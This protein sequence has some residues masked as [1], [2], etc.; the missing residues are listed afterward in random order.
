MKKWALYL[1]FAFVSFNMNAQTVNSSCEAPDSIRALFLHDASFLALQKTQAIN[2]DP[3]IFPDQSIQ[4]TILSALLAVYNA[5]ELVSS[6]QVNHVYNIHAA[7]EKQ[8]REFAFTLDPGAINNLDEYLIDTIINQTGNASFDEA[9]DLYNLK[10]TYFNWNYDSTSLIAQVKPQQ[11]LAIEKVVEEI[12]SYN[13]VIDVATI[14]WEEQATRFIEYTAHSHFS[15]L[16]YIYRWGNCMNGC[17]FE[18]SWTFRVHPNCD[19]EFVSAQGDRLN[20]DDLEHL[21]SLALFPNPTLDQIKVN[22]LGSSDLGLEMHLYNAVGKLM[23]QKSVPDH[24]GLI[25]LDVSLKEMPIGVY[26]L[27]ISNGKSVL[28]EKLVKR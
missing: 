7:F 17:N 4:D 8:L 27:S 26:F 9:L 22:L 21:I 1:V 18:H 12:A 6:D 2:L 16:T 15:E 10:L 5:K 3:A 14:A 25:Q 28:T 23:S 20:I 11:V 24:S 13:G 19:V